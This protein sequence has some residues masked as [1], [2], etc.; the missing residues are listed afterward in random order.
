MTWVLMSS[1]SA[2]NAPPADAWPAAMS[3]DYKM[4]LQACR[5]RL[6]KALPSLAAQE[7]K[8]LAEA[9]AA[10]GGADLNRAILGRR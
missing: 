8:E 3:P 9:Y 10:A 5:D 7:R 6:S 2:G 1:T 4:E